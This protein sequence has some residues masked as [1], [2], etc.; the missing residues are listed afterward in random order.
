MYKKILLEDILEDDVLYKQD[1]VQKDF[2]GED[3]ERWYSLQTS[4]E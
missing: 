1:H 2:I 3:F 4:L